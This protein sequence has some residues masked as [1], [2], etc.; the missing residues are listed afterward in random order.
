MTRKRPFRSIYA[1]TTVQLTLAIVLVFFVLGFAYYQIVSRIA[2]EQQMDKLLNAAQAIAG[3]IAVNIDENGEID[4]RPVGSYV[5]FTARSSGALVWVVN[6]R[7]EIILNTGIP[8]DV[9]SKLEQTARGYYVLPESLQLAR[10]SGTSGVCVSG[11]FEGLFKETK[12]YWLSAAYPLPSQTVAYQGEIQLHYLQSNRNFLTFL[13]T[14]GLVAS[15]L[16][17][18]AIALFINAIISRSLTRPIR[19]LAEAADK[20]ARGDL[21]VRVVLPQGRAR[22]RKDQNRSVVTDELTMLVETM[23]H[24]IE[25]L[26][27]Q[28]RDRNDFISSV[29]HDLRT[30]VTSIRG[31]VEGMLD[32]TIPPEKYPYYLEIVKQE[33]LRL[34]TLINTMFEGTLSENRQS[35][36]K[37]VFDINE[38]IKED[39]V[40]LEPL[41]SEKRLD[42][43]TDFYGDSQD[44]LLV[45]GDREAISRVVYNIVS[46]AIR[47]TPEDG[48]IAL[49]T[50]KSGR[51]KEIEVII[52]DS[53][54]GIPEQEYP[55]IFDRF[56][57]IDK[58]RTA[59]GSGLGL[60][61]CRTILSAHGQRIKVTHS[62][63]GGARFIFTMQT[64]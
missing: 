1:R 36:D 46:N 58:S 40:G 38:V 37:T 51:P 19:L 23:N 13:R 48:I 41:L 18:F 30:P 39:L 57:K 54:P 16:I 15:F 24:M 17:A 63:L 4:D 29:S 52:D 64:P 28:E 21:S 5:H 27:N 59:K 22:R 33:T 43:Q 20:V 62:D 31:F 60:Y 53:G 2:V 3:T 50:R 56:Y 47:F 7:G 9:L 12:G 32:G 45:I 26:S 49:T 42:V 14:N 10:T 61:I 11:D 34:Q 55:Y 25:R 44:R 35:L 6:N 8:A